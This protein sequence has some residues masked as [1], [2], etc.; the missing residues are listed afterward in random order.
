MEDE[1]ISVRQNRSDFVPPKNRNANL[2]KYIQTKEDFPMEPQ[3][4]TKPILS[5]METEAI[6]TL[7]KD[8]SIVIKEADKGG[9]TIIMD[10]SHYKGMVEK[11]IER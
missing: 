6:K 4:K 9:A 10:Q 2:E 11:N 1:D 3:Q 8:T 7:A 5:K